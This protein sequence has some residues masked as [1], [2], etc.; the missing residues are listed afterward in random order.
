LQ[1]AYERWLNPANFDAAGQQ[2]V[3]LS[4]LTRP[5]LKQRG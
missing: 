3:R 4:D 1:A 2:K 5:I